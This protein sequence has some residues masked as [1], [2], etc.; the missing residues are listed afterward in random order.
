MTAPTPNVPLLRK[1]LEH[2]EHHPKE[3]NQAEW[4]CGSGMCFAGWACTFDGGQWAFDAANP[5]VQGV[6]DLLI[7]EPE[8]AAFAWTVADRSVVHT[9]ERAIR[10]LGLT[11]DQADALFAGSNTLDDLRRMVAGLCGEATT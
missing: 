4:R 8:D 1:T 6:Q 3:W 10:V 2:I 7:A 5:G 11:D 9:E